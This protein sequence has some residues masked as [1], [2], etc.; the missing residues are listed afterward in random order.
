[1]ADCRGCR[2][3]RR[4][5][6]TCLIGEQSA[7]NAKHHTVPCKSSEDGFKVKGVPHNDGKN[8]RKSC[9]IGDDD[10]ESDQNIQTCHDRYQDRRNLSDYVPRKE[11]NKGS[12]G[13]DHTDHRGENTALKIFHIDIKGRNNVI[14]LQS[15]KAE[16]KCRNQGNGKNDSQPARVKRSL[17]I[18]C[19]TALKGIPLL[20][21]V[22]LGK[23]TFNKSGSGSE[24]RHQPHPECS[25]RTSEDDRHGNTRHI[26]RTYTGSR[27]N[28][29][30][31]KRGNTFVSVLFFQHTVHGVLKASDLY[32]T[33]A[34][35]KI[36][37]AP[38]QK[39][40]QQP[41][42]QYIVDLCQ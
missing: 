15:V 37:A 8:A 39:V 42:I 12:E 29:K 3:I 5:P 21:F 31:L 4:G 41:C 24:D 33:C 32:E 23:C 20:L 16:G 11:N 14:R 27:C 9:D 34:D 30:G 36:N 6:H 22:D 19:R 17:Y 40:D 10:K 13:K 38:C 18:V 2:S 25:T 28:H 1:M 26:S 35:R 7:L